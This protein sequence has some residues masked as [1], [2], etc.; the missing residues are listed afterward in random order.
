M[1]TAAS[2]LERYHFLDVRF[3]RLLDIIEALSD[4]ILLI[5]ALED[6]VV[7]EL[8]GEVGVLGAIGFVLSHSLKF[9]VKV[10]PL[11]KRAIMIIAHTF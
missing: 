2:F 8:D 5:L 3:L 9:L 11:F 7:E 4:L 10:R 1:V 6:E